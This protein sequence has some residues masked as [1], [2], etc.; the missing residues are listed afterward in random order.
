M[1]RAS[2]KTRLRVLILIEIIILV[3]LMIFIYGADRTITA[4]P[5]AETESNSSV[6]VT[7]LLF[8]LS[9]IWIV[10]QFLGLIG[11][12][13]EQRWGKVVFS[14]SM[15]IAILTSI[16]GSSGMGGGGLVMPLSASY[17]LVAGAII[18]LSF[19]KQT[20]DE[21]VSDTIQ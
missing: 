12:Y 6:L 21:G 17:W 1:E 14:I 8:L 10:S 7:L 16:S 5:Q 20:S 9:W 15:G 2:R 18:A 13:K 19:E 11:M 4:A 3:L